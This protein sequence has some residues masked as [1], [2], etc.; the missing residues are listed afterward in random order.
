MVFFFR[1]VL[2]SYFGSSGYCVVQN[3]LEDPTS[4]QQLRIEMVFVSN[5]ISIG[6]NRRKRGLDIGPSLGNLWPATLDENSSAYH[7]DMYFN[8]AAVDWYINNQKYGFSVH[9]LN[10]S[11]KLGAPVTSQSV[12]AMTMMIVVPSGKT[13]AEGIS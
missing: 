12:P 6:E 11:V 3:T 13:Q 10:D 1:R 7:R 9:C 8:F 4:K 5:G 2:N